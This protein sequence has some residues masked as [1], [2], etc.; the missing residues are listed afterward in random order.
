MGKKIA[1]FPGLGA[2]TTHP[3]VAM[4][5][6]VEGETDEAF[7]ERTDYYESLKHIEVDV[8]LVDRATAIDW[9]LRYDLIY[10]EESKRKADL[11][12]NGQATP[13][14]F[15][16]DGY[17]AIRAMQIDIVT[18]ALRCVRGLLV[19]DVDLENVKEAAKRT[20]MIDHCGLLGDATRVCR[21][22]QAPSPE[23]SER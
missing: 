6:R 7:K 2:L 21:D 1:K 15:T 16:E 14:A 17:R 22:A 5:V 18:R 10:A 12:R 19:G 20:E 4:P 11:L 3:L 8:E 23:Q 13:S 9:A